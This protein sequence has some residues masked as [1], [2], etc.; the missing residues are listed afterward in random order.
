MGVNKS[1]LPTSTPNIKT[2]SNSSLN[3]VQLDNKI[4]HFS[5]HTRYSL[6]DFYKDTK[7]SIN[8]K[9]WLSQLI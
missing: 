2:C 4:K 1:L 9:D 6:S 7:C 8:I 5:F 3:S